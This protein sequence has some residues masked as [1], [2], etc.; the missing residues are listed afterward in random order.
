MSLVG[1]TNE[2]IFEYPFDPNAAADQYAW[3]AVEAVCNPDGSQQQLGDFEKVKV[4]PEQTLMIMLLSVLLL[5]GF[6]KMRI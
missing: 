5:W 3:Y 6:R 2:P 1:E 4:G